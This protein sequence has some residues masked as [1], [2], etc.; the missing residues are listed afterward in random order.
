MRWQ[1]HLYERVV[2]FAN[3]M[4]AAHRAV[5]GKT[6][7]PDVAAFVMDLEPEVL[8]LEREL[9][10]SPRRARRWPPGADRRAGSAD[11]ENAAMASSGRAADAD[12]LADWRVSVSL[13][14]GRA[15]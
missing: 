14:F 3:L 5:R 15:G 13:L 9:L 10:G 7:R 1:G 2:T 4:A 6:E 12:G 11:V 8:Q